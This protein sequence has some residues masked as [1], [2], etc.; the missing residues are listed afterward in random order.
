MREIISIL[1]MMSTEREKKRKATLSSDMLQVVPPQREGWDLSR[2]E[3]LGACGSGDKGLFWE[4][5]RGQLNHYPA[6]L[7]ALSCY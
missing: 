2:K 3:L 5:I 6:V 7:R 1:I 4:C